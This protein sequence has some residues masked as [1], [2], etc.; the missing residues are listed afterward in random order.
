[1]DGPDGQGRR[2][3]R[4]R[5]SNAWNS[6]GAC[7]TSLHHTAGCTLATCIIW[8]RL[9]AAG[10]RRRPQQIV[11]QCSTHVCLVCFAVPRCHVFVCKCF[12]KPVTH[13]ASPHSSWTWSTTARPEAAHIEPTGSASGRTVPTKTFRA[14]TGIYA[15]NPGGTEPNTAPR[16]RGPCCGV[17]QDDLLELSFAVPTCLFIAFP[18]E[19]G[20]GVNRPAGLS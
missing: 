12:L 8:H 3:Q 14:G 16:R 6:A 5:C 18:N 4:M 19:R 2:R 9:Q 7:A 1:M 10:P 20:W 13:H 17:R 15:W 11:K